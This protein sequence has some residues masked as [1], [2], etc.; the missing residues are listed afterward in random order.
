MFPPFL[1]ICNSLKIVVDTERDVVAVKVY[2]PFT[3]FGTVV[4]DFNLL[5]SEKTNMCN[6]AEFVEFYFNARFQADRPLVCRAVVMLV[7]EATVAEQVD[8]LAMEESVT[9]IRIDFEGMCGTF[10]SFYLLVL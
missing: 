5:P 1:L 3:C 10:N 4:Y 6:Q 7:S 9:C 8:N 2:A